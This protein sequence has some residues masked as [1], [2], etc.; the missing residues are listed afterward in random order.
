[1]KR[2]IGRTALSTALLLV[3]AASTLRAQEPSADA[4]K[5]PV[6]GLSAGYAM[7]L[8]YPPTVSV[9]PAI[10]ELSMQ[11][12]W[13]EASL[14]AA[15]T[16]SSFDVRTDVRLAVPRGTYRPAVGIGMEMICYPSTY[17]VWDYVSYTYLSFGAYAVAIPLRFDVGPFL[18]DLL[19]RPNSGV[20]VSFL[21]ARIGPLNPDYAAPDITLSARLIEVTI[22][23]C[24]I[25]F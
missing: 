9:K 22:A 19:V 3:A 14:G 11:W 15:Y 16:L 4:R 2:T 12:G 6:F 13:W 24:T 21:E 25:L 5:R 17:N 20:L 18:A 8:T 23:R 7:V 10:S 1:M